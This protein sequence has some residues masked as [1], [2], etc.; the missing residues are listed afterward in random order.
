[1]TRRTR[2]KTAYP[3]LPEYPPVY[4]KTAYRVEIPGWWPSLLNHFIYRHWS[5]MSRM[6]RQDRETLYMAC[7]AAGVRRADGKRRVT[8]TL[9]L[10]PRQRRCDGDAPWKSLLDGMTK[11]G[12]LRDDS[13]DWVEVMPL[14]FEKGSER[15]A[16]IEIED[17]D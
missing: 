10:G 14:R 5:V 13:P 3:L 15:S 17:L 6:K 7:L 2:T 4:L 16:V 11:C 12:A 8:L 1:M 9:V